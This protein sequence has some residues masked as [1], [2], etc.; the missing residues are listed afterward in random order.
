MAQAVTPVCCD[1]A[2]VSRS[3]SED[4]LLSGLLSPSLSAWVCRS[5]SSSRLR[6]FHAVMEEAASSHTDLWA[7]HWPAEVTL[8]VPANLFAFHRALTHREIKPDYFGT[9][10]GENTPPK[11]YATYKNVPHFLLALLMNGQRL[12]RATCGLNWSRPVNPPGR[13]GM[14]TGASWWLEAICGTNKSIGRRSDRGSIN[15]TVTHP[16]NF[17]K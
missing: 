3:R 11:C 2:A 13:E 15:T 5:S 1:D 12:S 6:R 10:G 8:H 4:L 14:N 17:T 16:K 7:G 9:L